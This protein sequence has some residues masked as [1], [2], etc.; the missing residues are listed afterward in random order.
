[1]RLAFNNFKGLLPPLDPRRV[2]EPYAYDGRNF[3]PAIDGLKSDFGAREVIFETPAEAGMGPTA[4][5]TAINLP[6]NEETFYC[7]NTGIY[8]LDAVQ[9]RLVPRYLLETPVEGIHRWWAAEVNNVIFFTRRGTGLIGFNKFTGTWQRYE[10]LTDA[11]ALC[12]IA[13]RLFI[14]TETVV[15]WSAIDDG[16][17]HVASTV[18]GAGQQS[19]AIIRVDDPS[20]VICC[21]PYE[22][23]VITYTR[24]GYLR[25]QLVEGINPFRHRPIY[26]SNEMPSSDFSIVAFLENRHVW[27]SERGFYVNDGVSDIQPWQPLMGE[28][29]REFAAR[30]PAAVFQRFRLHWDAAKGWLI[31]SLEES[32]GFP[33]NFTIAYVYVV[34]TDNWG[35]FN[36]EHT[37]FHTWQLEPGTFCL[38][39]TT[40]KYNALM[41]VQD[42]NT[43]DDTVTLTDE[44]FQNLVRAVTDGTDMRTLESILIDDVAVVEM[45]EEMH[46][47]FVDENQKGLNRWRAEP[48]IYQLVP[49]KND[50]KRYL[51]YEPFRVDLDAS[52]TIGLMRA[53]EGA[54][55]Q[56]VTSLDEFIIGTDFL[57]RERFDIE[58]LEIGTGIEDLLLPFGMDVIDDFEGETE[59][60]ESNSVSVISSLDGIYQ[61]HDNPT[62]MSAKAMLDQVNGSPRAQLYRSESYGL[63]H[64]IRIET[65]DTGHSFYVRMLEVN[66][67]PSGVFP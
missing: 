5:A 10:F 6:N 28:H 60:A 38:M 23:G 7:N 45:K 35:S 1:M 44:E 52:V 36:R 53:G 66:L 26:K 24:A 59:T 41:E 14:A 33:G 4:G 18:T 67:R 49:Y 32:E 46:G 62:A 63:Y 2:N 48:G 56:E 19:L 50:R 55:I 11:V 25:S 43:V 57:L 12:E 34:I 47:D 31:V 16:S 9:T 54:D 65:N 40:R 15:S 58:D 3:V 22:Q 21:L 17:N 30:L 29:I 64:S 61:R 42:I 37:G 39:Y 27:I 8:S 20:D 13:G 51:G